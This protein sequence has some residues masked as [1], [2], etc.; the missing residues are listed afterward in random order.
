MIA[1]KPEPRN[2]SERYLWVRAGY[3]KNAADQKKYVLLARIDGTGSLMYDSRKWADSRTYG[4]AHTYIENNWDDLDNGA[5]IDVEY[6]LGETT[7][8]KE[9][10]MFL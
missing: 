1:I 5:V 9:S 10:E 6:I 4:V 2:E 3:G 7:H 8:C